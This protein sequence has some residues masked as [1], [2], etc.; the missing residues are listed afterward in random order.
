MLFRNLEM[1]VHFEAN[2]IFEEYF[3]LSSN[4]KNAILFLCCFNSK[5][6]V[7]CFT[8][9]YLWI[10]FSGGIKFQKNL[11]SLKAIIAAKAFY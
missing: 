3:I 10:N 11:I 1:Y 6:V 9:K 4:Q 2:Q 7:M 8:Y 5:I